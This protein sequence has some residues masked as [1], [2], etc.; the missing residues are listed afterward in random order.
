M[1]GA[2]D[3]TSPIRWD[4][5]QAQ[6]LIALW[7]A[8]P[9]TLEG[10]V[11]WRDLAGQNHGTLTGMAWPPTGT[12]G[13]GLAT[14]RSGGQ[15]ELRFDGTNDLVSLGGLLDTVPAQGTLSL[16]FAQTGSGAAD[17]R[18]FVKVNDE[19]GG[20]ID[21]IDWY[22][23]TTYHVTCRKILNSVTTSLTSTAT[24]QTGWHWATVTWGPGGLNLYVDAKL[25]ATSAVTTAWSS[26]AARAALLG[27]YNFGGTTSNFF[28]GWLDDVRCW[29]RQLLPSELLDVYAE[30]AAGN[31]TLLQ[32][33]AEAED[34]DWWPGAAWTP[35]TGD[36][37][38]T[39]ADDTLTSA[40]T[41]PVL[42][43]SA[44]T[45]AG[46]TVSSTGV[47]AVVGSAAVTETDD[48]LA[49]AG[50][51]PV[52]GASAL[53][54]A[55]DTLSSAGVLPVVATSALTEDAD[56]I[57]SAG[58]VP[59]L[60]ASTL[61]EDADTLASTGLRELVGTAAL[62]EDADTLLS[63]GTSTGGLLGAADLTEDGDTL[64]S[65]GLVVVTGTASLTEDADTVSSTGV[66]ALLGQAVLTEDAD[67]LAS[68]GTVL[69]TGQAVLTEGADLLTA[70]DMPGSLG[71]ADLIEADDTLS[72]A[73][74]LALVLARVY[75]VAAEDRVYVVEGVG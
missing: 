21:L 9:E 16:W 39:E 29:T 68:A 35:R 58:I 43:A 53:T 15:G 34:Q 18:L 41:V 2:L 52:V 54:E 45:E 24:Y 8:L 5:P 74:H 69:V 60:G 75:R 36:A 19:T 13:R 26:G 25:E 57:S 38:L 17:V 4:H 30:S 20:A 51:V 55:D 73:Q 27:A 67:T 40:G 49:S 11:R 63:S 70:S 1:R 3:L 33:D 44:L 56:S 65:A 64:A 62:T 12:S 47:L 48:T 59:V 61:T 37:A 6:G 22:V 71:D 72:A 31:P 32:W 46:D 66:M 28:P 23:D 14:T 7:L 42:G 50:T 10:G